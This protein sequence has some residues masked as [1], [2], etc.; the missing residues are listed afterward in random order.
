[1]KFFALSVGG[2]ILAI[3]PLPGR[4]GHY[5]EDLDQ[6]REWAP[7][8]VLSLTTELELFVAKS[9]TL[10][11]DLQSRGT[12]W[13]HLPIEDMGVPDTDFMQRWPGF[14]ETARRALAGG[15]RVLVHCHGGCGRSGMV[16]LRLMIESGDDANAA[17]KRL[18][19]VRPCAIETDAQ[20][21]WALQ[22]EGGAA[23]FVRHGD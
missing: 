10:G 13:V 1:M 4:D 8:L 21:V 7:A 23:T 22:P 6:L 14:S 17:L 2:G 18:R 12:R 5:A 19:N 20:M 9:Q 3:C 16:A 15:G 11:P